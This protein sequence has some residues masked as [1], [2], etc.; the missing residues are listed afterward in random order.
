MFELDVRSRKAIYEQLVD[1]FKEMI[2]YG[3]LKP[4]EQLPSVR[5]LSTELTVNP[6]TVQKAYRELEREGFIYSLQG[7]G[8]F[9]SSSV[10]HPNTAMRDE[11]RASLVKL[12]AEA[13]YA[14]LTKADIAL[15]FQEAMARI[16]KGEPN[17]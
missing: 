8:S 3:V 1:K 11:I 15:L 10:E 14:G 17:D 4:D 16:E 2:V 5:S 6:N 12:I 13:S 9:V 7:K